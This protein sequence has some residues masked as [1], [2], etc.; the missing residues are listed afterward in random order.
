MK[1]YIRAVRSYQPL[2]ERDKYEGN[3]RKAKSFE[4]LLIDNGYTIHG[5]HE[6]ADDIAYKI[7]KEGIIMEIKFFK[8]GNPKGTFLAVDDLWNSKKQIGNAI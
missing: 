8:G 6:Y 2:S 4:K 5:Y 1:R 3:Y 7:E